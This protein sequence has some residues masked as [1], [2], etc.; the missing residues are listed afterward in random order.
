LTHQRADINTNTAY[1]PPTVPQH[2]ITYSN[3]VKNNTY[4]TINELNNSENI[5][6]VLNKFLEDFKSMFNQPIQ[7]NSTI[8]NMLAMLMGK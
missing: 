7:Q 3:A 8:L 6:K 2:Q 5:G 4:N 1:Q